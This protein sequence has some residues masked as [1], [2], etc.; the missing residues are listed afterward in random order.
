[1][2]TLATILIALIANQGASA[3]NFD[4]GEV[5]SRWHCTP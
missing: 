3:Q 2:K 5:A 1:M 4:P